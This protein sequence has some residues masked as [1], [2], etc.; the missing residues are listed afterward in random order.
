MIF[1]DA[2]RFV[3]PEV[4][5]QGLQRMCSQLAACAG[6]RCIFQI[7]HVNTPGIS[8]LDLL[9]VF[10]DDARCELNPLVDLSRDDRYL[11][12]HAPFAV[13]KGN[14][15]EAMRHTFFHNYQLLW[16]TAPATEIEPLSS[17]DQAILKRQIALEYLVRIF[18][19]F[20]VEITYGVLKLR[21]LFLHAKAMLYDCEFLGIEDGGLFDAL[22]VMEK[23][24]SKWFEKPPD[25]RTLAAG[26]L[27]LYE[28]LRQ[29][30]SRFLEEN[31]FY[32]PAR[33]EYRLAR[34]LKLLPSH[35]FQV[36]HRGVVPP[37]VLGHLG[38]AYFKLENRLN[39]F[40]F[41]LPFHTEDIPPAISR[42][43]ALGEHLRAVNARWFPRFI[44][45]TSPL[46]FQ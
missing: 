4:Y 37:S 1:T 32:L 43:F 16:G 44:P 30:L 29:F 35:Q 39:H 27:S 25:C 19:S 42:L 31:H 7:G 12:I 18:M 40:D 26:I 21:N 34:H 8:D 11:F 10:E 17:E 13:S 2:P 36:V 45:L 3:T 38:P 41:R 9:V 6:V 33:S 23:R 5:E 46:S 14:Y 24:R 15:T 22:K 20:T 28:Q